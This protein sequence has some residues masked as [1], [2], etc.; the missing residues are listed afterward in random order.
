MGPESADVV[1]TR[2]VP[3]VD[4]RLAIAGALADGRGVRYTFAGTVTAAP[5]DRGKPRDYRIKR[6]SALSP[7]PGM[8]GVMR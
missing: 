3:S 4:A 6:D 2:L 7:V 8:P 5:V 1:S